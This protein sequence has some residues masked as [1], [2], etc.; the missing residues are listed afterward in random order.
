MS[1]IT[2]GAV[3]DAIK[4]YTRPNLKIYDAVTMGFLAHVVWRCPSSLFVNHYNSLVAPHH[5]EIGV[6]TGYCLDHCRA[7][8]ERLT[9]I[10]LNPNCLEFARR[11]LARFQPNIQVRNVLEPVYSGEGPFSSIALGGVLHCLP[12]TMTD[13][14][15]V[16]DNLKP[17]LARN[18]VVFGYTLVS[19]PGV[20]TPAARLVRAL[21]N[22]LG[23]IHNY[24]DTSEGL[25]HELERRFDNVVVTRAGAFAFFIASQCSRLQL[26]DAQIF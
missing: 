24:D 1:T 18:S 15:R 7:D 11:R 25:R 6:G 17:V 26:D 13:K 22:R 14:G 4:A 19:D 5:A 10:D 16:F 21:L 20:L 23:I 8:I 12:G 9:L 3:Q 2:T